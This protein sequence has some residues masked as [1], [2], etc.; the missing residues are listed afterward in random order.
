[1]KY[2]KNCKINVD[3][4]RNYCPLCFRELKTINEESVG[5]YP[6]MERRKNEHVTQSTHLL[7]KI[8]LFLSVSI[9]SVCTLVNMLINPETLWCLLVSS[10]LIYVW[11]LV[12]HTILSRRGVFEKIFMQLVG[13]MLI[14]WAC[15]ILS[16][17]K[18]HWLA[19]YVFP[20]ISIATV[21][22]M[23]MCTFI[24]R[25][26][27]WILAFVFIILVLTVASVLFFVYLDEFYILSIINFAF[28][29]LSLLGY[30]TFS[31]KVIKAEFLKKF[32]L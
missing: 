19:N 20:S 21:A 30:F 17:N 12:A 27:S 2:C 10:S 4:D 6:F 31:F 9:I 32:H 8:F 26:K 16:L 15:E 24:R 7:L 1:M 28:C 22:T 13:V 23:L 29:A 18:E 25:D 11:I 3:A 14:L 5:E